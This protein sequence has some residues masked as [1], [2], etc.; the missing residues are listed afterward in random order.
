MK[1]ILIF[2]FFLLCINCIKM[3]FVYVQQSESVSYVFLQAVIADD[4]IDIKQILFN[5]FKKILLL[6]C[7]EKR[8][9]KL[10]LD[11]GISQENLIHPE[12]NII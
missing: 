12:A 5:F 8:K 3:N 7:G 1:P 11:F 9:K 2:L 10:S 4:A 6:F